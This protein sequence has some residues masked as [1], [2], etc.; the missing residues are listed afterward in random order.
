MILPPLPAPLSLRAL[1][2]TAAALS[3]LLAYNVSPS[4]TFFN[5][6]LALAGWGALV[7]ALALARGGWLALRQVRWAGVGPVLAAL[8]LVALGAVLPGGA[9]AQDL[10]LVAGAVGLCAAAAVLLRAGQ[11]AAAGPLAV[12]VARAFFGAWVVVGVLHAVV[13]LVQVFAPQVADG[14]WIA[15]SS[16]AGRAVGNL[17]QPNHLSS[18]MLWAAIA[19]VAWRE[20]HPAP[21]GDASGAAATAGRAQGAMRSPRGLWAAA[22]LC[23]AL[24]IWAVVLTASRTGLVGV[25]LLALWGLADRR[26]S[27]PA[28]W[29]LLA[30]PLMYAVAWGGM[31]WWAQLSAHTFG[32]QQRLAEGDVSGSRLRIW[33]DAL[34]L[35]VAHP[36]AGVGWGNF[37][38]A[39]SLTPFPQRHTAFFDH[40]HNLPL[41][42]AVELGL[43]L[44]LLIC[45][46]LLWALVQ[47][48][49]R[50]WAAPSEASAAGRCALMMVLL[51]GLH[52]LLEYPLWYAYFLLPTAFAW[53]LALGLPG[54]AGAPQASGPPALEATAAAKGLQA[55]WL[56]AGAGVLCVAGALLALFDYLRVAEIFAARRGAAPLEQ[57]I[58]AGKHSLFFA[59]HAHYAAATVS[60]TPAQELASFNIATHHLLDTRLMMAWA[61]AYAQ[62]GD[63]ER[64]RHLAQRLRE[65]RNPVSAEFLAECDKARAEGVATSALPF[66]CTPP[67]LP[68]TWQDFLPRQGAT[69]WPGQGSGPSR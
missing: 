51:I 26:L 55:P 52:S 15:S 14:D 22:T 60:D 58:E 4:T 47:A 42:L 23:M 13:A 1:A 32:G 28:R 21:A 63:L 35:I 61:Q 38:F 46:L 62:A 57:R 41:Q 20:L 66:Q 45:G 17:R 44:A 3:T 48:G 8:A 25:V 5:Q 24:F 31:A 18:L 53:G 12:P 56:R 54:G 39:W 50:A 11:A 43:P 68:L 10:S 37:N 27:R 65:F 30:T 16:V 69:P 36:W 34:Q 29:L 67:A 9:G 40:T 2:L 64:A 33:A 6:A 7:W 49:R 19:L 59:H